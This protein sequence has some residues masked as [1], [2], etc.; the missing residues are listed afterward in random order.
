MAS[1]ASVHVYGDAGDVP[2]YVASQEQHGSRHVGAGA[3]ATERGHRADALDD[4]W[5]QPCAGLG[6]DHVEAAEGH[7]AGVRKRGNARWVRDI[8]LDYAVAV[9]NFLQLAGETVCCLAL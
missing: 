9:A 6:L 3:E 8:G 2:G 7:P 1:H 4:G 5:R